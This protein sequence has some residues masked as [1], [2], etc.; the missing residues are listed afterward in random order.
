MREQVEVWE[1]THNK[2]FLV[3]G[4]RFVDYIQRQW[5]EYNNAKESEKTQRVSCFVMPIDL[6]Q[7]I[8]VIYEI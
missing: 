5:L 3:E 6:G 8:W 4:S 1:V 2:E 7:H